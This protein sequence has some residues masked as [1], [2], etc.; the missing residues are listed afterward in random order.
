ML[1][2]ILGVLFPGIV[3]LVLY[4]NYYRVALTV[5]SSS[6]KTD[7][8]LVSNYLYQKYKAHKYKV[9]YRCVGRS[10]YTT[11]QSRCKSTLARVGG[12]IG[13]PTGHVAGCPRV[14]ESEIKRL[15]DHYNRIIQNEVFCN[16]SDFEVGFGLGFDLVHS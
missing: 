1:I 9:Y 11:A 14:S 16:D 8:I 10:R 5:A 6:R 4:Y 2:E 13:L 3:L 15:N 12:T 7:Q